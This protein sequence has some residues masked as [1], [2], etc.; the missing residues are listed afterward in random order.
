MGIIFCWP[1]PFTI[2]KNQIDDMVA[3]LQEAI[4]VVEKGL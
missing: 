3:I 1:P 2:D 4:Q